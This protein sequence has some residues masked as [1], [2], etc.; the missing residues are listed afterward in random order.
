M[1][2]AGVK[3]FLINF[4]IAIVLSIPILVGLFYFKDRDFIK[5]ILKKDRVVVKE[6]KFKGVRLPKDVNLKNLGIKFYME[7]GVTTFTFKGVVRGVREEDRS[8]LLE[9][10]EEETITIGIPEETIF[11][12]WKSSYKEPKKMKGDKFDLIKEKTVISGGGDRVG[13]SLIA[14]VVILF[15]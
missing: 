11:G 1:I 4:I 7:G 15:F 5:Q 8:V 13:D 12:K 3:D 2:S 9:A 10:N 14:K 6:G